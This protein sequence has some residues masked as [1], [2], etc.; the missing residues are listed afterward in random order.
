MSAS[1]L[2]AMNTR[3]ADA[4][5]ETLNDTLSALVAYLEAENARLN[6]E[7]TELKK[8]QDFLLTFNDMDFEG[9]KLK[10]WKEYADD[11]KERAEDYAD[12]LFIRKEYFEEEYDSDEDSDEED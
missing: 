8:E 5:G 6:K 1:F 2:S 7:N 11:R 10:A 9:K 3:A 4:P 12:E